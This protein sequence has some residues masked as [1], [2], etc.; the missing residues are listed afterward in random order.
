MEHHACRSPGRCDGLGWNQWQAEVGVVPE[1]TEVVW[2]SW[3]G[4]LAVEGEVGADGRSI[5]P[6]ALAWPMLPLPLFRLV[7]NESVHVGSIREI[8]RSGALLEASG[9]IA[10]AVEGGEL[11]L[12]VRVDAQGV[13]LAPGATV[14]HRRLYGGNVVGARICDAP[15]WPQ[16]RVTVGEQM[17]GGR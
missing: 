12:Q 4:V 7:E 6:G 1:A 15:A 17:T 2:R 14:D 3:S 8:R 10:G 16:A 13:R 5:E 11:Y 9:S